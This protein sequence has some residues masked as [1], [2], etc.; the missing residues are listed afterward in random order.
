[1]DVFVAIE[2]SALSVFMRE[3]LVAFPAA[4]VAHAIG[5]ALMAGGAFLT[6]LAAVRRQQW[7]HSLSAVPPALHLGFVLSL[8]SGLLLLAAY[9][10]KGLTNVVFWLKMLL[11]CAGYGLCLRMLQSSLSDGRAHGGM[12]ILFIAGALIA[13][14]LLAYTHNVLLVS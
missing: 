4:L 5:M 11:L 6:G 14:R 13:G 10:A 3:D 8:A 1:M 2:R 7:A 9:P 12:V